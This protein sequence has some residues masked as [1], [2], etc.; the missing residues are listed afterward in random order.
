MAGGCGS[1]DNYL[2]VSCDSRLCPEC[3]DRVMGQKANQYGV[4]VA[5]WEHPTMLRLSLPKRVEPTE[6]AISRAVDALRGAHGSLRR[7]VIPAD[8]PG[9]SWQEWKAKL[10]MV[11]ARDLAR[12][13]QKRYVEQGKGIP[14][15]EVVPT[16]FYGID[17]KQGEDGSVYVH[18]HVLADI[19]W[20]PQAAL[21][22][23]WDELIAAP[24]V[25]IRRVD[26]R[27]PEDAIN[28]AMEVVAYAAKPPDWETI[29]G[30]V[31]YYQAMKGSKLVQPFGEL[32]G[33]TPVMPGRLCCAD[34]G[35]IPPWW[36]YIGIV[37][38][39]YQTM[40]LM[41]ASADGDRPPPE[42]A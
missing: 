2:L 8:G 24:V 5:G 32:H 34:C 29:E 3:Q 22:H 42:G 37:N 31:A 40:H 41:G 10:C 19:P 20:L 16:G 15:K 27:G 14:F 36:N 4:V 21:S 33:N 26:G 23:L 12:R 28:A 18:M 35:E 38:G 17:L 13:W 1:D 9:W 7:R 30:E 39:A 11:G 25:D 6:E